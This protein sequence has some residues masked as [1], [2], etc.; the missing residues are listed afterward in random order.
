MSTP[1]PESPHTPQ[2]SRGGSPTTV[3][4]NPIALP[5]LAVL[6]LHGPDA[7]SFLQGQLTQDALTMT[8]NQARAG[9]YCSAKGRLLA[10]FV[11]LHPSCDRW[12]LI[13]HAGLLEPLVKRLKMFVL[14]AQC[15]VRAPPELLVSGVPDAG[16]P[17]WQVRS[18]WAEVTA[19]S[20][21][22]QPHCLVGWWGGRSL[23]VAADDVLKPAVDSHAQ[24]AWHHADVMAGWP[25]IEPATVEQFVPQMI[26]FELLGGVNFRKGCYPGQEVV[27]RSQYRGTLKRRM[28]LLSL[29]S[30]SGAV[31]AP[32]DELFHSED[33]GQPAGLVVNASLDP[34]DLT[35]QHHLLAEVKLSALAAGT[36]HLG[37]ADGPVL[38]VLPLPYAIPSE[39][40]T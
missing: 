9:G 27:A 15:S 24:Q 6:E 40:E 36:L 11:M 14:R 32:G 7:G 31:P 28:A 30:G 16:I 4:A 8:P 5:H 23:C 18:G 37:A 1:Q 25:W 2:S 34:Q 12:W 35:R 38:E 20:S 3:A 33:P 13:T 10:N 19:S 21:S 17:M 29:R 39:S 26:N 22:P